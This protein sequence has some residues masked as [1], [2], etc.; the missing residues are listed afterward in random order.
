MNMKFVASAKMMTA[1]ALVLG[2]CGCQAFR[3]STT[4]LNVNDPEHMGA[5]YDYSDM[6][7]LTEEVA[8]ELI[9]S[10]FLI[11]QQTPPVMVVVGVQNRTS[12]HNDTKSLT[13]RIRTMVLK[14]GKAQ[15]INESRRDELLREQGY[16]AA[17]ATKETQV[18]VSR[19]MGAKYMLSGSL[20]E[21]ES[22]SPR[23]ARLSRQEIKYY[24]LTIE[25]TDLE[26]SLIAWTTEKEFSRKASLPLIGW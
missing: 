23:Q 4:D 14:S 2:L 16:Q 17:N 5:S 7:K 13:D 6:R 11:K 20:V 12:D 25:V 10:E 24:K 19:Q 3:A 26:T 8:N 21:M 18:A 9:G 1:A 15:F 22:R